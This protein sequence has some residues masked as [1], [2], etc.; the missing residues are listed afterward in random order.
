MSNVAELLAETRA[1][2]WAGEE[3]PTTDTKRMARAWREVTRESLNDCIV[4]LATRTTVSDPMQGTKFYRAGTWRVGRNWWEWEDPQKRDR[5]T[6]IEELLLGDG[7]TF[8]DKSE[9]TCAVQRWVTHYMDVSTIPTVPEA[10]P[11]AGIT[12][13]LGPVSRD[14]ET[15]LYT[16]YIEKTKRLYQTVALYDSEAAAL[17]TGRRRHHLGVKDGD[18][19][20]AGDALTLLNLSTIPAGKIRTRRRQRNADCTQDIDEHERSARP[21]EGGPAAAAVRW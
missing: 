1:M 17:E 13:R 20:D 10:E 4:Y 14:R 21:G 18:K 2:L 12:Y 5:L 9:N 6:L 8:G 19:N 11:S 3:F 7:S 15:G 16:T